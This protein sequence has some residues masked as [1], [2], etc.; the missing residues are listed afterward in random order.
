MGIF[1]AVCGSQKRNKRR[2]GRFARDTR[3]DQTLLNFTFSPCYNVRLYTLGRAASLPSGHADALLQRD[4]NRRAGSPNKNQISPVGDQHNQHQPPVPALPS[5]NSKSSYPQT[6]TQTGRNGGMLVGGRMSSYQSTKEEEDIDFLNEDY[7]H[8][9]TIL[10][11]TPPQSESARDMEG[12][13]DGF[14]V[15]DSPNSKA[16]QRGA[17]TQL[18]PPIFS[19][20]QASE[21]LLDDDLDNGNLRL[22][23]SKSRSQATYPTKNRTKNL[24]TPPVGP[25]LPDFADL[26][27][28]RKASRS[29]SG[30]NQNGNSSGTS[31]GNTPPNQEEGGVKR[32]PSVVK[33]LRDRMVK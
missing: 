20:H 22:P 3:T 30:Y 5:P 15:V 25:V 1:R 31:T 16:K 24:P 27:V 6:Q 12:D 28:S 32:K 4:P 8:P 13:G 14:V 7:I 21:D 26:M 19:R 17:P 10:S 29:P 9:T 23:E 11:T 18:P 33:K 2:R